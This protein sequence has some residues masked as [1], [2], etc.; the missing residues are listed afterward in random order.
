MRQA[1]LDGKVE[2]DMNPDMVRMV[3][4]E[5]TEVTSRSA[6][7]DDEEI[8][9]YRS[10]GGGGSLLSSPTVSMGAPSIGVGIGPGGVSTGMGGG[11]GIG[12]G[13][14]MG[15]GMGGP[16]QGGTEREIIFRN[17]VVYKA[18]PAP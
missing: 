9:I 6:A 13:G 8:W 2:K 16:S 7:I 4:G 18:D 17:G 15:G 1:I 5:P 14:G 3:L 12:L 10:G 11:I